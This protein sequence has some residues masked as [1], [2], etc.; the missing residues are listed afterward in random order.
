M[1]RPFKMGF[2][3]FFRKV[4]DLSRNY[5][6]GS[7]FFSIILGRPGKGEFTLTNITRRTLKNA[8]CVFRGIVLYLLQDLSDYFRAKG[9]ETE[10]SEKE[11][12]SCIAAF[13]SNQFVENKVAPPRFTVS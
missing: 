5:R 9:P 8:L 3:S 6:I 11:N 4:H 13:F 12:W 7:R 10:R 2:S 1:V